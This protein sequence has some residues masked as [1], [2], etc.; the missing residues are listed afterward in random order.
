MHTLLALLLSSSLVFGPAEDTFT[1]TVV[2]EGVTTEGGR[3]GV[4]LYDAYCD[5]PDTP[6]RTEI[7][8][9]ST[10]GKSF[11]VTFTDVPAGTYALSVLDDL[12]SNNEMDTNLFGWP[13]EGFAFSNNMAP[14]LLGAP[15]F[16]ACAFEVKEDT[17]ET[18]ILIYY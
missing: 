5:W 10:S 15:S 9:K 1:V 4:G 3:I 6:L 8:Q 13:Q 11:V 16:K 14:N 17:R 12:N 2:V 18:M 7:V